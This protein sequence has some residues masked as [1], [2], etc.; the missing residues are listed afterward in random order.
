MFKNSCV[1]LGCVATMVAVVS[2]GVEATSPISDVHD[3]A[4]FVPSEFECGT[5]SPGE[6]LA[7]FRAAVARGEVRDPTSRPLPIV[8]PG[9]TR[10]ATVE[11][12]GLS[13]EQVFAFEDT[14]GLLL[15]NYSTGQL[16]ALMTEAA[17][18]VLAAHGDN[19]DFIGYWVNFEPHHK[20]GGAFYALI[21]N[22]VR[23]IGLGPFN[24]RPEY[25]LGGENIE[26]YIMMWNINSGHWQPGTGQDAD[27]T[28]L[29]LAQEFEHRFAMFLPPLADGRVLQGDNGDC[30]RVSHWNWQ[31]DGQGSGMEIAEWVGAS[32]A[33]LQQK[34]VSFNTDI[35][36]GVFSYTDLYL[37]G[38]LSGAQMDAGNSELRFMDTSDCSREYSGKISKFTSADIIASAG[39]RVPSSED[40]QKNFRT[41]WVMIH[42]PGDPPSGGELDK[43]T[44]ILE[45]HQRD[46]R[47]STLSLGTMDDSL[48]VNCE[49]IDKFKVRCRNNKLKAKIKS[50]LADGAELTIDNGGEQKTLTIRSAGA[51]KVKWKNQSGQHEVSVVECKDRNAKVDCGE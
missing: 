9:R 25:G 49:C 20:I 17:N 26:G 19:Y 32:P 10:A 34:F 39:Q 1:W 5:A 29:A 18:A 6:W 27:F 47:F 48:V 13:R 41:A 3:G 45:Q 4:A 35:E 33:I 43:A 15:T 46:W 22:N 8:A 36:G 31:V 42:R 37:M 38:Y 11:D 7:E 51:G 50:T 28:R 44:A 24:R 23:G 14:D 21:E 2:G 12:C 16:L 40:S 30:G